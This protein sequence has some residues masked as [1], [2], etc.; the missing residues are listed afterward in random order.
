MNT[1]T[2]NRIYT[3]WGKARPGSVDAQAFH[4]LPLHSLDVAA[5]GVELVAAFPERV[6]WLSN[7]LG[8]TTLEER[9]NWIGFWLAIHD[10][11]KFST[12]FQGQRADLLQ[13]RSP[14]AWG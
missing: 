5:V 9:Q 13:L 14:Q 6:R 11:G 8:L 12:A 7:D 1:L 2:V 10:L 4:P 3:Y